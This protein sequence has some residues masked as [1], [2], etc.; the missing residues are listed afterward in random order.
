MYEISFNF[1]APSRA[2]G[3]FN[4]L[5]KYKKLSAFTVD[6]ATFKIESDP[7]NIDFTWSPILINA[8]AYFFPVCE[9][10]F[11]TLPKHNDKRNNTV[12]CEVNAFVEATPISGPAWV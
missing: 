4:P 12:T 2:T 9:E 10:R 1:S 5:P 6:F 7:S 3:K 8:F 11:R